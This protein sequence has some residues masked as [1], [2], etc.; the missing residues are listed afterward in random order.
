MAMFDKDNP[1]KNLMGATMWL[2]S[3]NDSGGGG[4]DDSGCGCRSVII[5]VA[6]FIVIG[7]FIVSCVSRAM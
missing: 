1:G 4:S 6:I 2:E 3:S 5:A 7:Y